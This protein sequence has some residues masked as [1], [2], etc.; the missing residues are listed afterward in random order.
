MMP[1]FSTGVGDYFPPGA[2][3][4]AENIVKGRAKSLKSNVV[5]C[6]ISALK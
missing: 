1:S 4:E 2:K 5:I 3:R 6:F